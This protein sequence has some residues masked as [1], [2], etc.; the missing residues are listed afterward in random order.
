MGSPSE[1]L[2]ASDVHALRT[3]HHVI[4]I[5]AKQA[6]QQSIQPPTSVLAANSEIKRMLIGPRITDMSLQILTDCDNGWG[7]RHLGFGSQQIAA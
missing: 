5:R 7:A 1:H 4:N 6:S 2:C 3:R